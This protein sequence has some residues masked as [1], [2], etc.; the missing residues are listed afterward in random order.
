MD[1]GKHR[2]SR[3]LSAL[4]TIGLVGTGAITLTGCTP[5]QRPAAIQAAISNK[6]AQVAPLLIDLEFGDIAQAL[7]Q[8]GDSDTV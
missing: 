4:L 3:A 8:A 7:K 6:V 2:L 5:D 1:R